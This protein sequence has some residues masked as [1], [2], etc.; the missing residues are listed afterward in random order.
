M[1]ELILTDEQARIVAESPG[2][3]VVRDAG[4]KVLGLIEPGF[5]P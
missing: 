1:S 5:T 4:G 2:P 3:V